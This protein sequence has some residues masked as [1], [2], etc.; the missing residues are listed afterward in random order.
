MG[1]WDK[2]ALW[3]FAYG[4]NCSK[5]SCPYRVK[6]TPYDIDVNVTWHSVKE[7]QDEWPFDGLVEEKPFAKEPDPNLI[8]MM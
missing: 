2:P 8:L 3:Q 5:K 1:N 6:G 4:G 7:I